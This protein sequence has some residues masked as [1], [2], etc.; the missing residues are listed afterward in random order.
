VASKFWEHFIYIANAMNN[1]SSENIGLWDE[2][3]G[4]YYDVLHTDGQYLP[5]RVRSIV[6]LIPLFAVLTVEANV[7]E[8]FP[9]FKRRLDWFINNRP[10]LTAD[11]STLR[12]PGQQGRKLV[13][14]VRADRL[15]RILTVMLDEQEFLSP[16][17]IRALSR[18]HK[19][20]PYVLNVNG[21][22]HRVDYEPAESQTGLFGGNSNWRGPIWFPVNYLIIDSLQRFHYYFGDDFKVE[23]PTGSGQMLTLW[24]V[25]EEISRRLSRIFLKDANNRRP[26]FGGAEKF[27]TDPNWRDLIPFHEY[28]NGDN[29]AGIGASHQTGW[30]GLVAK[31]LQQSGE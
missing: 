31:L 11:I 20:H 18:F 7:L 10:D 23:C 9:G 24:Q 25:A 30:T 27:Q 16:F 17:G 8:S 22:E 4:F 13:S 1:I 15:R 6:G 12:T 5:L 21:S 3:D 19:D 2:R 26:V 14:L 29:G 28:F